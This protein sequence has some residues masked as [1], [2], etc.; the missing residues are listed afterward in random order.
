MYE[1]S[2]GVVSTT[3]PMRTAH[4][5]QLAAVTSE[6][7]RNQERDN[8]V[9]GEDDRDDQA[10]DVVGS[11]RSF[12]A[13]TNSSGCGSLMIGSI[14]SPPAIRSHARTNAAARAKNA[15]TMTMKTTSRMA[16]CPFGV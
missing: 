16:I 1:P 6:L 15:I 2:N 7:L 12:P 5:S 14:S 13:A 3:R 11:H 9:S 8:Q 4:C 10:H